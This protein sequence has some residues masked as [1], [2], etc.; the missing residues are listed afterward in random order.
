MSI[1]FR[2]TSRQLW[3]PHELVPV[4]DVGI[5]G[6][7]DMIERYDVVELNTAVK[8]FYID[9]LYRRDPSVEAVIYLDPDILVYASLAPLADTLAIP[10]DRRDSAQLH[11]R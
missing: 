5:D 7:G 4:E 3:R 8:P 6:L 1:A 11:L 10:L 2:P 9:Y